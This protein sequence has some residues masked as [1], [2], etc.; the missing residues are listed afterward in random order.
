MFDWFTINNYELA[1][2]CVLAGL[3]IYQ[4]WFYL[5]YLAAP[6]RMLRCQEHTANAV[7][8]TESVSQGVAADGQLDLFESSVKGVSVIVCARNE[9]DNLEEYLYVLLEQDYPLY[10][11]IVVNDGSEDDTQIVV[12]RYQQH[13]RHLR[14]TFVPKQARV[15]S[16]KKLA[17]TLG[18]KASHFDYLLLTDADCRPQSL[19]WISAMMEGCAQQQTEMVL[20]YGAYFMNTTCINRL[21][22]Y[23]TLFNGLQFMGQALQHHPYMGVGRNLLYKKDLF[24]RNNGFAGLLNN[25][26]GDDDLFVNKVATRTNTAVVCTPDS[27]TWSVPKG[28]WREWLQQKRRH[29]SVA[30]KYKYATK[31]RLGIE[32]MTR[33]LWYAGLI[34]VGCT[35]GTD[36]WLI[37]G[38]MFVI[39]YV[40]QM[41]VLSNASR[42][43]GGRCWGLSVLWYDMIL[44]LL[45]AEILLTTRPQQ[46]QRW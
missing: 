26:S 29:L 19:H 7:S 38:G 9:Q 10:E 16:T 35:C 44:P 43:L 23:D 36:A 33:G 24:M 13:Y 20:G 25:L 30:P 31:L 21:I 28:S 22:Q 1:C 15:R 39:R 4:G 37:A 18:V 34:V 27:L 41:I 45:S 32:P 42:R 5:R 17:L 40:M 2:L 3:L 46:N 11:V 12:E 6:I 8:E 14:Y